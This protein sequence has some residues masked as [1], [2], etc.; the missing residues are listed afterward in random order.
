LPAKVVATFPG[1]GAP[2]TISVGGVPEAASY[3][4][5][6]APKGGWAA[7]GYAGGDGGWNSSYE[8]GGG[9]GATTVTSGDT[10]LVVAAGGGGSGSGPI[11]N[12]DGGGSYA[13]YGGQAATD[14]ADGGGGTCL[15]NKGDGGHA[16]AA[17]AGEGLAGAN[18]YG[19]EHPFPGGGGGGGTLGGTGGG[20]GQCRGGG[21]AGSSSFDPSA[22]T[23]AISG[24]NGIA[25]PK[26]QYVKITF[27]FIPAVATGIAPN[28]GPLQGGTDVTLTG[29]GFTGATGV[30]FGS[31]PGTAFQVEDDNT[32]TV[33]TPADVIGAVAVVVQSPYG[34]SDGVDF[35]YTPVPLVTTPTPGEGPVA[36]GSDVTLTGFQFDGATGV[37]FGGV[38]G[39]GFQVIDD[40]T[41]T[42]TTPANPPGALPM[43]VQSPY[44]DSPAVD[45]YYYVPQPVFTQQQAPTSAVVGQSYWYQFKASDATSYAIA[46]SS[47]ETPP[48]LT[49]DPDNGWLSALELSAQDVG[50]WSYQV[51]AS[52]S[53]GD[54]W[55]D[56][57]QLNITL[58]YPVP[59]VTGQNPNWGS[60]AGGTWV[61][62][63]GTGFMDVS[64]VTYG[65]EEVL[66][67][68]V[69]SDTSIVLTT[70][71]AALA[72][73][74]DVVVTTPGGKSDPVE[75]NYYHPVPVVTGQDPNSGSVA[76][77]TRVT[78]TGT[79]F[80]DASAVTYGGKDAEFTVASD[81]SIALTTPAAA[82]A[83]PVDVVV[84]TPG[85][86]SDPVEFDYMPATLR[87]TQHPADV[88][89][90]V[91]DEIQLTAA[92]V[93]DPSPTV[94]WQWRVTDGEWADLG[95]AVEPM[96]AL[97]ATEDIQGR[98]YRAVFSN[99]FGPVYTHAAAITVTER[100]IVVTLSAPIAAR[101][102]TIGVTATGLLR[103]EQAE[104][105]LDGASIIARGI[106][107]AEGVVRV[108]GVIA[109]QAGLGSH[110]VRV[111]GLSSSAEGE[112]ALRVT[113][114]AAA[115]G[116]TGYDALARSGSDF[117]IGALAVL[118]LALLAMGVALT[119]R[120]AR[121]GALT[122][123]SP[124]G[125]S[126]EA[127]RPA[128]GRSSH[129][130]RAGDRRV[131]R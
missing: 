119:R 87:I 68:E 75:F 46:W 10:A 83:G 27:N 102:V 100:E 39:T 72:G 122:G 52:N 11:I 3:N 96:L 34:D 89:A 59:V 31:F 109:E 115:G 108:S 105:W 6:N 37:T 54:T 41:I 42:V 127:G 9:G 35:T 16:G 90:R 78:L 69:L 97:T 38:P 2:L 129:A 84:T 48:D 124:P 5:K 128:S 92:A 64:A 33:T 60:V 36:G 70:P 29:S 103:G 112:A 32:I 21:G 44:G 51:V 14:Y 15:Y 43:I 40:N 88:S 125:R 117:P 73:A 56:V 82:L 63:T 7:P 62:L 77:G 107:D 26:V 76:G 30:T 113:G 91:G 24:L 53:A 19:E 93:G 12:G 67:W 45:F 17:P 25:V 50:Q 1:T 55:S 123:A 49:L 28:F 111:V 131:R 116:R 47:T 98:E 101:G 126:A 66:D 18:G 79:G 99:V 85:G 114:P 104:V 61:A 130:R 23:G 106:A 110:V 121:R 65:G 80:T 81:T 20:A 13:G 8:G 71:A 57:Q 58:T 94:Q 4:P 86:K 95:G 22:I 118:A 74:V 120:R